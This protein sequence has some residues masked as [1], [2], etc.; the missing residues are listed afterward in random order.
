MFDILQVP[1]V[2]ILAKADTMT[3]IETVKFRKE[4][5]QKLKDADIPIYNTWKLPDEGID[6]RISHKSDVQQRVFT[7]I[8]DK[9]MEKR[10][11]LWGTAYLDNEKHSD[12]K[13][14]KTLVIEEHLELM[15]KEAH[16]HYELDY[17]YP[18]FE[19]EFTYGPQ[20]GLINDHLVALVGI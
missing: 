13:L 3:E 18:R 2:P 9:A 10:V 8:A 14:L 12:F 6:S 11:Y 20:F 4:V 15:M 17:R 1:I 7:L 5:S 19:R 16:D